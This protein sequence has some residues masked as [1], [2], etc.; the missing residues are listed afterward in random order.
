MTIE[1]LFKKANNEKIE[2]DK[3]KQRLKTVLLKNEYFD[4]FEKEY[5]DWKL[6]ASS[7]AFS[8]LII[9]FSY[10]IPSVGNNAVAIEKTGFYTNLEKSSNVTSLGQESYNGENANILKMVEGGTETIMYFNSRNVLI[11]SEVNNK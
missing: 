2:L 11:H 7:L 5:W 9:I 3:H 1:E 10:S 6:T 8:A 4:V